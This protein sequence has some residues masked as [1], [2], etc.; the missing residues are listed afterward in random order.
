MP[1]SNLSSVG[2]ASIE[3][4]GRS[5]TDTAIKSQPK[6]KQGATGDLYMSQDVVHIGE[7]SR[8][9]G[10]ITNPQVTHEEHQGSDLPKGWKSKGKMPVG[11]EG[12]ESVYDALQKLESLTITEPKA[13]EVLTQATA[14][15]KIPTK[16]EVFKRYDAV[17]EDEKKFRADLKEFKASS[18]AKENKP[19]IVKN[20][21][22]EL[23][24]RA[25]GIEYR[26]AALA[27]NEQN[28]LQNKA[29]EWLTDKVDQINKTRL[30]I[31]R[32]YL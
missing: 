7:M 17:V 28:Y 18:A 5:S 15:P 14:E 4:I 3:S 16:D 26:L 22:T 25:V 1:G 24:E 21:A 13:A 2:R 8:L 32:T 10:F 23:F 12:G 29:V 30:G 20:P 27:K 19:S 6:P 31:S 11:A 9:H